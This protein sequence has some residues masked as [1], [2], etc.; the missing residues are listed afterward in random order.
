LQRDPVGYIDGVNL[1]EYV[2][3]NPIRLID[4][5]GWL[6]RD[7]NGEIIKTPNGPPATAKHPSGQKATVQ[8][9]KMKTAN[10]TE[11][12]GY[13][14]VSGDPGMKTDCHGCTFGDGK[15]WINDE[16]VDDILTG[17]GYR[18]RQPGCKQDQPKPGDVWIYRDPKTKKVVHSVKVTKVDQYGYVTEV[19]GLGGVEEKT[20]KK[21]PGPGPGTAWEKKA[22]TEV[23]TI[24]PP[25]PPPRCFPAGTLV[26]TPEGAIPIERMIGY[27]GRVVTINESRSELTTSLISAVHESIAVELVS[28]E[29]ENEVIE[30]T[31]EHPFWTTGGWVT[32]GKLKSSMLLQDSQGNHVR[33]LSIRTRRLHEPVVVYNITVTPD[34]CY[35]V[36]GSKILVHNKN[37][38]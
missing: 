16:E 30:C 27:R 24:P 20:S 25:P 6:R 14:Y 38:Y 1:Y 33:I 34:H 21:A 15:V 31:S 2:A 3:S 8:P 29:L 26:A 23:W 37:I 22:D 36:G 7:K 9:V 13:E 18:K 5:F 35:F 28:I 17:D 10:G 19:E 11:V 4:P 12:D 32:A